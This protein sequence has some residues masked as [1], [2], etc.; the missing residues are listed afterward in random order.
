MSDARQAQWIVA[1]H[2]DRVVLKRAHDK[3]KLDWREGIAI[4]VLTN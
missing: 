3:L 1:N 4:A 2:L